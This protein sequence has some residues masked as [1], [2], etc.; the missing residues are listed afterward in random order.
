VN[1]PSTPE[2]SPPEIFG[3]SRKRHN[4]LAEGE[5]VAFDQRLAFFSAA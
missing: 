1:L 2:I 4:A 5:L 3:S